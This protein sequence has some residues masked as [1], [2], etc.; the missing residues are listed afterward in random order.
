[1]GKE[2]PTLYGGIHPDLLELEV[3]KVAKYLIEIQFEFL[4]L[5]HPDLIYKDFPMDCN[6]LQIIVA[7]LRKACYQGHSDCGFLLNS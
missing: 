6:Q 5:K 3:I 7:Q 2:H 1:M 4:E